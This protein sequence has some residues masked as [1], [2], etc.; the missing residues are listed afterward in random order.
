[1]PSSKTL[2]DDGNTYTRYGALQGWL[3]HLGAWTVNFYNC[4]W[5]KFKQQL[6][7]VAT[8]LESSSLEDKRS[9]AQLCL[10]PRDPRDWSPPGSSV[11]AWN[12][13]GKNTGVGCHFLL[14]GIF[15]IQ[16]SDSCLL[17]RQKGSLPLS[18]LGSPEKTRIADNYWAL[19]V[20][21]VLVWA[22][23]FVYFGSLFLWMN[24][25]KG[26]PKTFCCMRLTCRTPPTEYWPF[27]PTAHPCSHLP[28]EGP[29]PLCFQTCGG[30]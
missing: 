8:V 17:H 2:S 29:A 12:F 13:L 26:C 5:F 23:S 4:N 30:C 6:G 1:M 28:S 19:T 20:S 11:L 16:G 3:A 15:S 14:Q 21:W 27:N 10:T 24:A 7:C 22:T 25:P 9:H 18:C